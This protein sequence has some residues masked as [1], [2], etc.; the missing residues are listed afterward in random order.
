M[1][2]EAGAGGESERKNNNHNGERRGE[3]GEQMNWTISLRARAEGQVLCETER[4]SGMEGQGRT[5]RLME[6]ITEGFK[7]EEDW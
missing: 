3:I 4:M 1:M 7:W 5:G 6:K 2:A